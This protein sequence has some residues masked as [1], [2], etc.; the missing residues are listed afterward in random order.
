MSPPQVGAKVGMK[1]TPHKP[2]EAV[3]TDDAKAWVVNLACSNPKGFGYA[4]EAYDLINFGR[5]RSIRNP[6]K[7]DR[8]PIPL[9]L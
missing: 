5:C 3:I 4:A 6:M 9:T 2:W 8:A 7:R 1:D